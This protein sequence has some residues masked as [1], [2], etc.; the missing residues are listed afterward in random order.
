MKILKIKSIVL[1]IV[2]CN[3]MLGCVTLQQ[4]LPGS[5]WGNWE[6][7]KTGTISNGSNERLENY[8]N[9]C[10][11][12]PDRLHFSS[13]NKM[14]L[15]WYDESCAIHYYLIG[16]YHVEGNTLKVD[17]A[18]SRPYQ[19]SPFPP[20]T[21]FRIIQINATTLKLEE[22]PSDY[23]RERHQGTSSGPEVLVFVFMRLE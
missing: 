17:L 1:L 8:R 14:S 3:M 16:R 20:I 5:L 2:V 23:R 18:D 4:P 21:E 9:V 10:D 15:R 6:F 13:D 12:E 19:D 7:V 11:S 22:I